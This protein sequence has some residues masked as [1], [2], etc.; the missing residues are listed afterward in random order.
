MQWGPPNN[1][2]DRNH[3]VP[4]GITFGAMDTRS[5]LELGILLAL[6]SLLLVCCVLDEVAFGL[7]EEQC[8]LPK[9]ALHS[10]PF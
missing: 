7:L 2:M 5:I 4:Y 8:C 9:V 10:N 6:K 3:K 1:E